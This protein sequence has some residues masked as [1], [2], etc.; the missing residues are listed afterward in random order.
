VDGDTASAPPRTRSSDPVRCRLAPR[1][2]ADREQREAAL[3]PARGSRSAAHVVDPRRG[4]ELHS[5]A[6]RPPDRGLVEHA[7]HPRRA[8]AVGATCVTN[9]SAIGHGRNVLRPAAEVRSC[10]AK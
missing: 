1:R 8:V 10:T 5:S 2:L 6:P 3:E 9:S 7:V 4:I